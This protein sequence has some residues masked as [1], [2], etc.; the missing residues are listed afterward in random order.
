MLAKFDSK[1]SVKK[2]HYLQEYISWYS[3]YNS[4]ERVIQWNREWQSSSCYDLYNI[5]S[6]Y[7]QAEDSNIRGQT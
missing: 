7:L 6:I 2:S 1:S 3:N 5:Y 4:F